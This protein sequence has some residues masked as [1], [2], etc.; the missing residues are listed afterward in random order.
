MIIDV[1]T[2]VA[3]ENSYYNQDWLALDADY[4]LSAKALIKNYMDPVGI[5]M[6]VLLC[7][8]TSDAVKREG[9]RLSV[10]DSLEALGNFPD[11][12]I[13]FA[14]VDAEA[15]NRAERLREYIKAGCRGLGEIKHTPFHDPRHYALFEVCA[16]AGLPVLGHIDEDLS[17]LEQVLRD[18]PTM[19]VIPH[20]PEWWGNLGAMDNTDV[21]EVYPKGKVPQENKVAEMLAEYPNLYADISAGSGLNALSRDPEYGKRFAET[22]SR[23][24]I[25]GTDWPCLH[26]QEL[27][28]ERFGEDR[29]HLN[30]LKEYLGEGEALENVLSGNLL[31]I[32]PAKPDRDRV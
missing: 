12:V 22:F 1:H 32:L 25:Y 18:F 3:G 30:I 17:K 26:A 8:D 5:D 10:Q 29:L 31:G 16:E 21:R 23:K 13:V 28:P 24:L 11:R 14:S 2:H 6:A 27:P 20:G 7:L 15:N 19:N 4:D 9:V